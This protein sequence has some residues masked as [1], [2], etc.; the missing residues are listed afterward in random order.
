MTHIFSYGTLIH[1]KGRTYTGKTGQAFPGYIK[2]FVRQWD[3]RCTKHNI[4]ALGIKYKKDALCNG[5][6][7]EIPDTQLSFFDKRETGYTRTLISPKDIISDYTCKKLWAYIPDT[8][9]IANLSYPIVQTYADIIIDGCLKVGYDFAQMFIRTTKNWD[10]TWIND[11]NKPLYSHF[12]PNL[13]TIIIDTLL[14]NT[15]HSVFQN[16]K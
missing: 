8:Y 10:T 16:R 3:F 5:M 9:T 14:Q 4:T 13:D 7:I 12:L 2:N 11:R 15:L 6:I 1:P